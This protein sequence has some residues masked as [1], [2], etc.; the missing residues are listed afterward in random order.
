MPNDVHVTPEEI[1]RRTI[2][3]AELKADKSAFIDTC[4]P[5]C[6]GKENYA[7]IGPG[8]SENAEQVVPVTDAHGFNLGVAAMPHG[9][10]NSLHLHYTAEVFSCFSGEWLFRW[11]VGGDEGEHVIRPGDVI[12]MPTWMFRGFTN[13]GADDGWMFSSLGMD[14][15]GGIIWAPSVLRAAAE[16]GNYLS[17]DNR[18][19]RGVPGERPAGVELTEPMPDEEVRKLRPVSPEQM[20]QR[21]ATPEDLEWSATPFLDSELP[22]GGAELALV[23]GYGIT[24]DRDQSPRVHNPH[25]FSLAWLRAE[26][27]AGVGA[28]RH[29]A[30]QV[31]M[32]KDG[33]WRVTLNQEDPVTSELGPFDTFSVPRG[34]WRKLESIGESTGLLVVMTEG[35]GRVR[36]EW[37]PEIRRA[38]SARGTA[39]D[40]NGYLAPAA[41]VGNAQP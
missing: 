2:R 14:E 39:Y 30:S 41:L 24:E 4:L 1:E 6:V 18:L 37:D 38:A 25:G 21:L 13:V 19:I 22:G 28:H 5:E 20:R 34:A 29:D 35:D 16:H 36:A 40:T 32:V 8:V 10:T 33:R 15:T 9:I 23:V 27:G 11:G 31:F 7:L 17:A 26:P 12:S 3:R